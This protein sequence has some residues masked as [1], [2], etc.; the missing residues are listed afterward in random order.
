MY[1]AQSKSYH[2]RRGKTRDAHREKF[3]SSLASKDGQG[4]LLK[5]RQ[6][7]D[8]LPV[9]YLK[10]RYKIS[11]VTFT[12]CN[13]HIQPYSHPDSFGYKHLSQKF[14]RA[15]TVLLET[16]DLYGRNSEPTFA[17][18]TFGVGLLGTVVAIDD[19]SPGPPSGA[20]D[21][22]LSTSYL[23]WTHFSC[24]NLSWYPCPGRFLSLAS[25]LSSSTASL[26]SCHYRRCY[27]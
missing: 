24:Q 5:F 1:R 18:L 8:H 22:P 2:R 10:Q 11:R 9:V 26:C 23:R 16:L 17:D 21:G 3:A 20:V 25:A 12:S 4:C 6:L 15:E 19:N 13:S 14:V 27:A 7:A